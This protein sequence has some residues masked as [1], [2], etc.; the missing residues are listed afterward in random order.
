MKNLRI[1]VSVKLLKISRATK[2]NSSSSSSFNSLFDE[3]GSKTKGIKTISNPFTTSIPN[4]AEEEREA[5]KRLR[6]RPPRP[7]SNILASTAA[8]EARHKIR[9]RSDDSG[10]DLREPYVAPNIIKRPRGQPPKPQSNVSDM[11]FCCSF[12]TSSR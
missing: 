3:P 10:E 4:I 5:S 9:F 8:L 12:S 1:L 6:G 7:K 2:D 11:P